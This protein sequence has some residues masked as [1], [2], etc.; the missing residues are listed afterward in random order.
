MLNTTIN[1]INYRIEKNDFL[2][3]PNLLE[4]NRS[5]LNVSLCRE[6]KSIRVIF[7]NFRNSVLLYQ[8][9]EWSILE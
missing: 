2:L 4:H 1:D 9:L 3:D 6:K 8:F 7:Y 5:I